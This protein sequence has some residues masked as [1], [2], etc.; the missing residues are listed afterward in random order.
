[1][2]IK[3]QKLDFTAQIPTKAH[4]SD[5]GF[6]LTAT[7]M[8]HDTNNCIVY[9]TGLAVEIPQGYVG[10]V[11]PRSSIARKEI[12]LSN[13]VGVIDSGYRGEIMAKFKMTKD[14]LDESQDY[15]AVGDRIAQLIIIPIPD[16]EFKECL[17][18]SE[19]TRGA[20]GYG[21]TGGNKY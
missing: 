10:L 11:F 12:L 16:I 1:M 14:Y 2:I 8:H 20:N 3:F 18:L 7:S 13:A 5:A 9:G 15:Y 4:F 17:M 21:S 19:S 6:D